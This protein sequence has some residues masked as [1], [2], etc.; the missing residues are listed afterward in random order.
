[1]NIRAALKSQYH[2]AM[3]ML[4][5]AVELCPDSMWAD[6]GPLSACKGNEHPVPF[7]R[8]VYHTLHGTD[9]YLQQREE[10]FHPWEHHRPGYED[11]PWPPG[12][13]PKILEPYTKE[14]LLDY[15]RI[16]DEKI[17]AG[18]EKLDLDTSESGFSWHKTMSKLEHQLQN[19]RHIQHHTASL[20]ARLRLAV[21]ADVRWVRKN[22]EMYMP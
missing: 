13:G 1:M 22:N 5:Q 2:A 15:W 20:A 11:L 19:I 10:D 12:S 6:V 18:V 9:L 21:G 14:Q 16:C 17:D 7:W 3:N 4:K 8:I